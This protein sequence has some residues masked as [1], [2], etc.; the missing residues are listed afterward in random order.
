LT[1]HF[2]YILM[3]MGDYRQDFER[4]LDLVTIYTS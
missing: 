4:I 3:C 2:Y 1:F